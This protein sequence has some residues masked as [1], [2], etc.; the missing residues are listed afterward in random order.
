MDQHAGD[1]AGQLPNQNDEQ[2]PNQNDG[3]L[4]GHDYAQFPQHIEARHVD[5]ALGQF[6]F[7]ATENLFGTPREG[8]FQIDNNTTWASAFGRDQYDFGHENQGMDLPQEQ[9]GPMY[10]SG[11]VLNYDPALQQYPN[12]QLNS[13]RMPLTATQPFFGNNNYQA[14]NQQQTQYPGGNHQDYTGGYSQVP[15]QQGN[16]DYQAANEQ[17][18]QYLGRGYHRHPGSLHQALPSDHRTDF[19]G[20]PNSQQYNNPSQ[21]QASPGYLPMYS[22]PRTS[23]AY[24]VPLSAASGHQH[25]LTSTESVSTEPAST[26]PVQKSKRKSTNH[27]S[28]NHK[29]ATRKSTNRK[30]GDAEH[31]ENQEEKDKEDKDAEKKNKGDKGPPSR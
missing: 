7:G 23:A 14:A 12:D 30:K 2:P 10:H 31:E 21:E 29:S 6:N 26:E 19:P 13:W 18:S 5:P 28:T 3:H 24:G 15:H 17:Q 16:N 11:P 22:T 9:F 25:V 1:G 27:K 4:P 8:Q 20:L